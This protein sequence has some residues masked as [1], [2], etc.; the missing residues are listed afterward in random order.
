[1]TGLLAGL[2][3][4]LITR[5]AGDLTLDFLLGLPAR[6]GRE[7]GILPVLAATGWLTAGA[8]ALALP[9]GLGTALYLQEYAPPGRLVA[10]LRAL[11]ETLA[12]VPSIL[13]G[14]FGYALFVVR[15]GWGWSLLSGGATLALMLLPTIIRTSEEALAAVPRSLR[16]G[17]AALGA[18]R[19]Q[20]VRRVVL[21]AAAPGMLTGAMLALGRALGETAAV[22]LT[23]GSDL[24][25]PLSPLEPGR[26]MAVHLY[27]LATEGLS[28]GR[29]YATA[30][31][32]VLAV[33]SINLC[34]SLLAERGRR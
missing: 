23:A 27:I 31:A 19:W 26:S 10:T 5:G 24:A 20:A 13:F 28:D 7:G 33:L 9:L 3:A 17:A 34:A 14:L 2:L 25:M 4:L 22:L 1:M 29:A 8:L 18:T 12:G 21:K 30:L 15:L 32:L 6:A 16:E 11:V